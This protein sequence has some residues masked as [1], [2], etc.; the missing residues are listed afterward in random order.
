M[1]KLLF[2]VCSV[3]LT[4]SLSMA[5]GKIDSRWNCAKATTE[6]AIDVGDV[7]N[8]SY[9]ISQGPCTA[10]EGTI[11]GVKEKDGK[12]IQL[13]ETTGASSTWHGV[14]M[15]T[16][17]NGDKINFKF[18]GSGTDKDGK[19]ATGSDKWTIASGTGKLK[20]AKGSGTCAGKGGADGSVSWTCTGTYTLAK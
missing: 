12:G 17:A 6:N 10:T 20:G 8:H 19:F 13:I 15:E 7:P 18:T 1:R 14:F 2:V 16:L 3:L 4:A 11:E 5:Q 9:S